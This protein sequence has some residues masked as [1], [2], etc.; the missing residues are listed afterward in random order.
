MKFFSMLSL[1]IIVL[2]ATGCAV[3]HAQNSFEFRQMTP[4]N[5]YGKHETFEI[6]NS[7][8]SAV[9]NFKER[10]ETCLTTGVV[11]KNYDK[12]TGAKIIGEQNLTYTPTLTVGKTKSELSIQKNVS[13]AGMILGKVPENGMYIFLA[14]LIEDGNKSRLDVYYITYMGTDEILNAV[15]NWAS[16][17]SLACP[18]LTK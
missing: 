13:G 7:Y 17:T 12:R 16:G 9:S 11:I 10:A 14:D 6:N 1:V 15:K 8:S 3:N 5:A 2:T 18:D 4:N